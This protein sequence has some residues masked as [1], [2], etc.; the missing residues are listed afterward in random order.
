MD[1][2]E[3]DRALYAEITKRLSEEYPNEK[4]S[5]EKVAYFVVENLIFQ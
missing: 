4:I 5:P 1:E 3:F 2:D